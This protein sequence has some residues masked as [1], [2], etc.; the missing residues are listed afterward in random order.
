MRRDS[1]RRVPI[2]RRLVALALL[3][4]SGLAEAEAEA[5]V[6][7][8]AQNRLSLADG[9]LS[10]WE[11]FAGAAT[12]SDAEA[13]FSAGAFK[14]LPRGLAFGF[15]DG[16]VWLH[17]S[18]LVPPGLQ[19]ERWLRAAE[20]YIDEVDVFH[21]LP[22]GMVRSMKG[23]R[24][25]QQ[26]IP[27]A[28]DTG[29]LFRLQL[30]PGEHQVFLRLASASGLTARPDLWQPKAFEKTAL[31]RFWI[32]GL[33]LGFAFAS[34]MVS[35]L[36]YLNQGDRLSGAFFL[37]IVAATFQ[38][39]FRQGLIAQGGGIL[40]PLY[41]AAMWLFFI[42]LFE[43]ARYHRWLYWIGR[44]GVWGSL[45]AAALGALGAYPK[46]GPWV[47]GYAF[48]GVLGS[49]AVL[50]RLLRTPGVASRA[51]A[52]AFLAYVIATV[53]ILLRNL[54]LYDM[55]LSSLFV[56]SSPYFVFLAAFTT[57]LSLRMG[58]MAESRMAIRAG[59]AAEQ[60]GAARR[61]EALEDR[62]Q[63]L[64]L[65]THELRT[66]VARI[67]SS[68]EI[69][70]LLLENT[71]A[72]FAQ[73]RQQ[74]LRTLAAAVDRLRLVFSLAIDLEQAPT[75]PAQ[76][77][78]PDFFEVVRRALD[79]LPETLRH[80]VT[81]EALGSSPAVRGDP[82]VVEDVLALIFVSLLDQE[83]QVPR[84][85]L[86]MAPGTDKE[87]PWATLRG[88]V[89]APRKQPERLDGLVLSSSVL[90]SLEGGRELYSRWPEGTL[91]WAIFLP[92]APQ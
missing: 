21:R 5:V 11:D 86:H 29:T 12:L 91:E 65:L 64:S 20:P 31:W 43:A 52:T 75:S 2:G 49:P 56:S 44:I 10:Y 14:R 22:N 92:E 4:V 81:V 8:E 26:P 9:A 30:S 62:L 61:Q 70:S 32:F 76:G 1:P 7:V 60:A 66:P 27:I 84:L 42:E 28:S 58:E 67:N 50:Y 24:V 53:A 89:G 15:R 55:P 72:A 69:L 68:R 38:W 35:V 25:A 46:L 13:E 41:A 54:G 83:G 19:E 71:S 37:A 34:S 45:A 78:T 36:R 90:R 51:L 47:Q 88:F 87:K 17:F 73:R 39:S 59:L 23:G 18:L 79:R 33:V 3:F 82:Q 77:I 74:A 57:A 16:A 48:L 6:V 85:R 63:L 40:V 80:S